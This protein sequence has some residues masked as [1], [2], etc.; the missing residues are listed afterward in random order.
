MVSEDEL[1]AYVD[2]ELPADRRGAVETWLATHADDAA[3]VAAWRS[4]AELL[5]ARYGGVVNEPVPA[6]LDVRDGMACRRRNGWIAAAAAAALAAFVVGGSSAGR[7]AASDAGAVRSDAV[8]RRRARSLPA[9]RRRGAPSGRGARRQRPICCSGCRSGSAR[10]CVRPISAR[11]ASSSSAAGCCPARP[12]RP[13]SSCTKAP[14]ASASRS[15]AG[16]PSDQE[17]AFRYDRRTPE[18]R[19]LLGRAA[20]WLCAQRTR[21]NATSCTTIAQAAYDQIEARSRRLAGRRSQAR[22][23][24]YPCADRRACRPA[25]SSSARRARHRAFRAARCGWSRED[26]RGRLWPESPCP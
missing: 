12:A 16:G 8:H 19:L 10:R 6:R 20:T 9:L 7:R 4:Q 3:R 13:R 17:T 5:R 21:R 26:R 23:L 15:I 25:T 2:G 1:H 18:R 22:E 14:P 11:S 24:T